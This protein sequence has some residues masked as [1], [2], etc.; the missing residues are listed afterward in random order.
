MKKK[1]ITVA[2]TSLVIVA[3][4]AVGVVQHFVLPK[5]N[6]N[7]S[8]LE[9]TEYEEILPLMEEFSKGYA[10]AYAEN[11]VENVDF[12]VKSVPLCNSNSDIV[13]YSVSLYD[14]DIPYGYINFDYTTENAIVD[15]CINKDSQGMY[16]KLEENLVASQDDISKEDCLEKIYYNDALNF[17]IS[18][19]QDDSSKELYYDGVELY[20]EDE[21][22]KLQE[23]IADAYFEYNGTP[24]SGG[25][26]VRTGDDG[27]KTSAIKE[28]FID[29]VEEC[30]PRIYNMF[31]SQDGYKVTLK[32]KDFH[33]AFQD[34]ENV[35][36]TIEEEK[37]LDSYSKEKSLISQETIMKTTNKFACALVGA[38]EICQQENIMVNN[39]LKDTFDTLWEVADCESAI[40]ETTKMYDDCEVKLASTQSEKLADIMNA[41]G[42]K[43][44]KE[45]VGEFVPAPDFEH[46][47]NCVDNQRPMILHALILKQ[48]PHAVNTVGYAISKA[49]KHTVNYLIIADGWDDDAPRYVVFDKYLFDSTA[50]T[51]FEI[52]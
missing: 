9:E 40:Y 14:G 10:K 27:N 52:K 46:Y 5:K 15:Y 22:I 8:K 28:G 41:Y 35:M 4:G 26:E 18:A 31:F 29:F 37:F 47:K 11:I 7:A 32:Y 24:T 34:K 51:S 38:A 45:I 49:G 44:G 13:G 2:I 17:A 3:V 23:E 25:T 30:F 36:G 42:K 20:Q 43:I 50:C 1:R 39:S 19:K 6:A 16:E 33:K 48:G 21:Y 12:N